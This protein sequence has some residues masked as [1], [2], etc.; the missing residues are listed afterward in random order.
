[1]SLNP[2]STCYSPLTYDRY[3]NSGDAKQALAELNGFML[4]ERPLRV[5][6]GNDKMNAEA[7]TGMMQRSASGAQESQASTFSGAG[8]RGT[9]A[10]GST[11]FERSNREDKVA[12]NSS[13]LDDSDVG[14]VNY[15]N[16]SRESL[17][18]KLARVEEPATATN[19]SKV[20]A[21]RAKPPV[22]T[23]AKS[24]CIIVKNCYDEAE[25]VY[26]FP[27]STCFTDL[28]EPRSPTLRR[29]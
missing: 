26:P 4:A 21:A 16:F 23:M 7:A 28:A 27:F 2:A 18:K 12:A 24:R 1:M 20:N 19:K 17:M 9:H 15:S 6:L 5:G 29:T 13:A 14:G 25:Y 10:G 11:N 3:S 22:A 8:G